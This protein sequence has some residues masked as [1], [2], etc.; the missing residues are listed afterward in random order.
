MK[1]FVQETRSSLIKKYLFANNDVTMQWLPLS[2]KFVHKA[3]GQP[4]PLGIIDD[5]S[6]WS[7]VQTALGDILVTRLLLAFFTANQTVFLV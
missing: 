4:Q 6:E 7:I 5:V 3:N 1:L 2:G